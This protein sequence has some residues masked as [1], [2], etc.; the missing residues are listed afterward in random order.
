MMIDFAGGVTP[1]KMQLLPGS[2]DVL[3]WICAAVVL[4]VCALSVILWPRGGLGLQ[5]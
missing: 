3:G 5:C 4:Y 1:L 2:H